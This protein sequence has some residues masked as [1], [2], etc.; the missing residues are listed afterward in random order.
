ML[1]SKEAQ[2]EVWPLAE[3]WLNHLQLPAG[4]AEAY[5]S[6]VEQGWNAIASFGLAAIWLMAARKKA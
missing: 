6:Y 1:V 4:F 3:Y 2:R 5:H